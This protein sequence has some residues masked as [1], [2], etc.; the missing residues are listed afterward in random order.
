MVH[1]STCFVSVKH[2]IL[3]VPCLTFD[4]GLLTISDHGIC[5]VFQG[6]STNTM[7]LCAIYKNNHDILTVILVLKWGIW[8][9]SKSN[10]VMLL[11]EVFIFTFP[12]MA[13][14]GPLVKLPRKSFW[15]CQILALE[16]LVYHSDKVK[17]WWI[18]TTWIKF[19]ASLFA[20]TSQILCFTPSSQ[21]TC[22]IETAQGPINS[23]WIKSSP[24]LY[25]FSMN[26]LFY[27][28]IH[29]NME[30]KWFQMPLHV[31]LMCSNRYL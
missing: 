26:I 8:E 18:S 14:R 16:L 6:T 30:V 4:S 25:I 22:C 3:M 24:I 10:Y 1:F 28:E 2:G 19:S 23:Q 11:R 9:T 17:V 5:I 7:V 29:H 12:T 13:M 15:V 20:L 21:N 27:S 31:T